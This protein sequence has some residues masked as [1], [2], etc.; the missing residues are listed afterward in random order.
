[1]GV[2]RIIRV[3]YNLPHILNPKEVT[4]AFSKFNERL[5]IL[6]ELNDSPSKLEKMSLETDRATVEA[7]LT[8]L[9]DV[10]TPKGANWGISHHTTQTEGE[11]AVITMK[12]A[13]ADE[14]NL[15]SQGD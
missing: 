12:E 10:I 3:Y 14:L 15:T 2:K 13:V 9:M 4:R 6:K 11:F 7:D 1:M 8:L 5:K